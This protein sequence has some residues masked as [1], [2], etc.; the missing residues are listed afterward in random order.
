[1]LVFLGVILGVW[2]EGRGI[3]DG[4]AEDKLKRKLLMS[5]DCNLGT[6]G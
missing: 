1:M 4:R 6:M 3:G 5:Y 2:R